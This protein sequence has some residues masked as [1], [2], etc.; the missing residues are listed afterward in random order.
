MI[1]DILP[2][3]RHKYSAKGSGVFTQPDVGKVVQTDCAERNVQDTV[4]RVVY[5]QP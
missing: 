1:A 4:V 2:E 3:Y 5:L